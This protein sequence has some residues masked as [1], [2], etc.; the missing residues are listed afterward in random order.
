M[1]PPSDSPGSRAHGSLS[2]RG[3]RA[4]ASGPLRA[5][6]GSRREGF[7]APARGEILAPG[8]LLE[9]RWNPS[10]DAREDFDRDRSARDASSERE[11]NEAE[12]VLS[13]DGG[14][15][16]R[17]ACRASSRPAH[18]ASPGACPRSDALRR[19]SG[20]APVRTSATRTNGSRSSA[21]A[22]TILP[23]PE[24]RPESI[25]ARGG[26]WWIPESPSLL[27]RRR[28]T[29][30]RVFNGARLS[31]RDSRCLDRDRRSRGTGPRAPVRAA[32][33]RCCPTRLLTTDQRALSLASAPSAPTPLRC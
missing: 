19:G 27:G 13:L 7:A 12:I 28:R 16:F 29:S 26:E 31:H 25:Y 32:R 5:A 1:I 22:F 9:I 11:E 24:H 4:L 20:C 14:M 3:G 8:A 2:S 15:T 10:C 30:G 6:G 23:D 21:S 18:R 33:S 17:S